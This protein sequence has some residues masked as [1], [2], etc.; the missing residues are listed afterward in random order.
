MSRKTPLNICTYLSFLLTVVMVLG[1]S[2]SGQDFQRLTSLEGLSQSNVTSVV[3]DKKGFVWVG[4]TDG[5]NQYDGYKFKVFRHNSTRKGSISNN[6]VVSTFVDKAGVLYVGT[7]EGGLNVYNYA[8]NSF[9]SYRH[10]PKNSS[11]ISSDRVTAIY[12]DHK[13]ELWIGTEGGLDIFDRKRKVFIHF[14]GKLVS[15]LIRAVTED[16]SN[17]LWIGTEDGISVIAADRKSSI[18]YRNIPGDEKSLSANGIRAIFTDSRGNVWI[19]TAFGGLNVLRRK[20]KA[21]SR[22]KHKPGDSSS[23]LGD[24]VPGICESRDGKIWVATNW[25]VSV[26]DED[27]AS[28]ENHISDPYNSK[29]LIDNGLNGIYCDLEGNIWVSSIVGLSVKDFHPPKFAHYLNIPGRLES[30]GSKE[31]FSFYED[32][33]QRVWIGLREGFDEFDRKSKTFIHHRFKPGGQRVGTVTSFLEDSRNNFWIGTFD[34]GL[35]IYDREKGTFKAV[36]GYNSITKQEVPLRDI[37]YIKEGTKGDIYIS[38]F[39]TGIFKYNFRDDCFYSLSWPGKTLPGRGVTALHIGKDETLYIGTNIEGLYRINQ[40]K[41]VFQ[42]YTHNA[43]NASSISSNNIIQLH[44]DIKGRLWI[45]TNNGLNLMKGSGIFQ[46]FGEHEGVSN[47]TINSIEE[48]YQGNLWLGTNK[49]LTRFKPDTR[50]FKIFSVKDG[51]QHNDFLPRASFAL[52]KGEILFGGLNGFNL[53][54]PSQI[55]VNS[56]VPPVYIT[57]FQLFNKPVP[58][59]EKDSPLKK[60]IIE[61]KTIVLKYWQSVFSFEFVSLDFSGIKN[62]QYAYKLEGFEKDWNFIGPEN[63]AS[64]TNLDPGEYT[65]LV[66][67]TNTDGVWSKS[68]TRLTIIITPPFWMTVWFKVLVFVLVAGSIYSIYLYRINKIKAQKAELE[69]QVEERTAEVRQK[70]SELQDMNEELQ[71]QAEELTVQSEE[72]QNQSEHLQVLNEE[73]QLQREYEQKAREEAEKANL[74]KSTFLATMSHEIR[75][76]MNGVLGM[77]ALLSETKLDEEQREYTDTIRNSGDA[78]LSVINDILDFSK[79]ESGSLEIDPHDF[80]IRQCVEDVMDVFSTKAANIGIDLVSFIDPEVPVQVVGDS[81]RLRQV[82]INLI[83]NAIKFTQNGEVYLSVSLKK[84]IGSNAFELLFQV[85]D[86]GIGIPEDKVNR[87]FRAFSQVDSSTTRKYGGTGLGLVISQR[88]IQL[89]GG[90]I[91]VRSRE[92]EGTTFE[93]FINVEGSSA[94]IAVVPEISLEECAGKRVLIIDDNHTNLRILKLQLEQWK[95]VPETVI[96]GTDALRMLSEGRE[97]ELVIS[98]MQMPEMDGVELSKQIK[99]KFPKLPIILL[100][101]IGDETK[102]KYPDLFNAILTKPIKQQQLGKVVKETLTSVVRESSSQPQAT[103]LNSDFAAQN[104]LNILIAED[105]L[106]NQKLIT[107]VLNKLGYQPQLVENGLQVIE[108]ARELKPDL[109]FMDVHMPEMDG[110]QATRAIR[111]DFEEQ[112]IIVAM[113]ANAMVED[114]E[115][116]LASGMD[117]YISKPIK[118]EELLSMLQKQ[119]KKVSDNN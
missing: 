12:E 64:Y 79:I 75:T 107:R 112:P 24:Y 61:T 22:F 68:P 88:L 100:S 3:Q 34:A 31:V 10:N 45:G 105:N 101:S 98:D 59:G 111:A 108:K 93:F 69:K 86:T 71:V 72:L 76:P 5:L 87:L 49:G 94:P 33:R 96:S 85:R 65:F 44:E 106:V 81:M 18:T 82:L 56:F 55:N 110:L 50:S 60:S 48:D 19:G 119:S 21:F 95:L 84:Q 92:G 54:N 25:G 117:D 66:K 90:E 2:A 67:S 32:S 30:L 63:K 29:S 97:F 118:M 53:F 114:K 28:F 62:I 43:K 115:E 8:T 27:S 99:G 23:L 57:N 78:L 13:G 51:L 17:N 4:T 16:K 11:S 80:S 104:P 41:G 109:I 58:L 40:Q 42:Q 91:S 9:T 15:N 77:A 83:G 47:N 46:A 36:K 39:T 37:W 102:K 38:T 1:R 14:E 52:Y 73:L 116:C 26:F 103:L 70:A 35:Q 113:T 20:S 6:N 7:H 74:A 89:M